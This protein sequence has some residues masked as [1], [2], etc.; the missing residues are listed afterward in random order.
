M[1]SSARRTL[2]LVISGSRS[3]CIIYLYVKLIFASSSWGMTCET[4]K[5]YHTNSREKVQ[6]DD[7]DPLTSTTMP[8]C[9]GPLVFRV[10]F[11]LSMEY[12][13]C[14]PFSMKVFDSASSLFAFSMKFPV[15]WFFTAVSNEEEKSFYAYVV[16]KNVCTRCSF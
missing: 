4:N 9:R 1:S 13:H 6:S 15:T 5:V 16:G 10:S 2:L 8:S 7:R 3:S 12:S 14:S 11:S